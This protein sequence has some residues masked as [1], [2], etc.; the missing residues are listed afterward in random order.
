MHVGGH[1]W[2]MF[3]FIISELFS[4]PPLF[5]LLLCTI[6]LSAPLRRST[7]HPLPALRLPL[8]AR[9]L[10]HSSLSSS[11]DS[12]LFT[13]SRKHAETFRPK[14]RQKMGGDFLFLSFFFFFVALCRLGRCRRLM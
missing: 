12:L 14:L 3:T 2:D 13:A 5:F 8:S 10:A 6:C 9:F 4:H 11:G 7:L 1:L